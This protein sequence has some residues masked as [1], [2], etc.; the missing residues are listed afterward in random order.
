MTPDSSA[1]P[2]RTLDDSD[3][4][5]FIDVD[6]NA[7][8]N[9]FPEEMVEADREFHEPGRGIGAFDG[10]RLVGI[11]TAYPFGM[12]VP[13]GSVPAAGVSWVGVLPTHRRRGVLSALMDHQLT[14]LHDSGLEPVAV[15]WASEP[16]IYGRYGYGQASSYWSLTVGRSPTALSADAPRDPGLRLRLVPADDWKLTAA[17][18]DAA[19]ARRPGMLTRDERWWRRAVRDTPAMRKDASALR[20]VVAEDG[21]GVRGY[22]RYSTTQSFGEDFG[23][24]KVRVREVLADDS[25]ALATLYRYLFDLDLMGSTELWNVPVDDPVR[26]WLTNWRQAKPWFGDAL[27]VRLVDLDT[28]LTARRYRTDV[29]LVLEVADPRCP[30]NAGRWRLSGGTD[31]AACTRTD[32]PADLVLGARDLG[33]A[34]LGGA[35]FVELATAGRVAGSAD[36]LQAATAAFA[37]TPAPWCPVVF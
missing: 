23:R 28:A 9:T 3:W 7:F 25:A 5:A 24:G 36:A 10:D 26:H 27:Y 16:A 35:S 19:V 1:W 14:D 6:S 37:H 18:Y 34:Y 30:W 22:A 4:P 21:S 12:T 17:V 8:G 31:G 13:G 15:L 32:D 2:V 20:C 33:A 29:D 11:A